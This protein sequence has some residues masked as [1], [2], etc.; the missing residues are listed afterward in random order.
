MFVLDLL[1]FI[2][3]KTVELESVVYIPSGKSKRKQMK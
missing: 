3:I 2:V 1:G